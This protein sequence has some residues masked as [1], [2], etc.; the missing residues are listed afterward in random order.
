MSGRT[1]GR[2]FLALTVGLCSASLTR[3]GPNA[4][5]GLEDSPVAGALEIGVIVIIT[6]SLL[7]FMG[8]CTERRCSLRFSPR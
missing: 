4:R 2:L 5:T 1:K 8:G 7:T 6:T 3:A